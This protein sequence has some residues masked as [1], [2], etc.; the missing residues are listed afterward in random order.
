MTRWHQG[1]S[2]Q[3][4]SK[5]CPKICLFPWRATESVLPL[6]WEWGFMYYKLFFTSFDVVVC[7]TLCAQSWVLPKD[8]S[9]FV[10]ARV[11]FQIA[12]CIWPEAP[13]NCYLLSVRTSRTVLWKPDVHFLLCVT[14]YIH[15]GFV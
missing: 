8:R 12:C 10:Y 11:C 2:Y 5:V 14:Y 7:H 13:E 9:C 1:H 15:F 3:W 4:T 6:C